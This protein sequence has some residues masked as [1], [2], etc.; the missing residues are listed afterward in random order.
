MKFINKTKAIPTLIVFVIFTVIVVPSVFAQA[1]KT[2][3]IPDKF[4]LE[5]IRIPLFP[6]LEN[7]NNFSI[8]SWL[9]FIGAAL[10]ALLLVYWV[11]LLIKNG[12]ELVNSEGKPEAIA[13]SGKKMRSVLFAVG[14]T[15]LFP[16]VLSILGIA[17]GIGSVFSWPKMLSFCNANS[18]STFYFQA[19]FKAE[20]DGDLAE[21]IADR[22]CF[23]DL[24]TINDNVI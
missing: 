21:E 16:F 14:L 1:T 23:E 4:N 22:E 18:D 13:E 2:I 5:Q 24:S 10:V 9:T 11:F 6:V 3:N 7:V 17:I 20:A 19:F 8:F 15:L 12:V